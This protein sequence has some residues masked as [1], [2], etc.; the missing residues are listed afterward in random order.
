MIF[1]YINLLVFF[2]SFII[3]LTI[4]YLSAPRKRKIVVYPKPNKVENDI[5]YVDNND[6]CY[7]FETIET[8]CP[9]NELEIK[10][11]PIQ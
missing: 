3:G 5:D 8:S 1:Q 9:K 6:N 7:F 10:D 2:L 11:I 4:L